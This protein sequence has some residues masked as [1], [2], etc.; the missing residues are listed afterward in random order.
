MAKITSKASLVLGT[1]LKLHIA[2]KS[3]TD[4]SITKAGSV[5]TIASAT[6]N[7]TGSSETGGIV[8]RAIAVGDLIKL[9]HTTSALNEGLTATVTTASGTSLTANIV[10]GTGATESA[11]SLINITTF[12]KTF[13]FLEAGGLSF[14][15]G[16]QGIILASK[17]VD[18][19][20]ASDL[21]KYDRV[22]ASIEPRA[23]SIAAVNGW[24]HHNTSTL[25]A[26]RDT[27]MEIRP[28]ATAAATKIY[29]LFRSTSNA[30]EAT[31]QMTFWPSTDA[32]MTAPN[33]FVMTG[34]A[35]QLALIYDY[36]NGTP[37]DNRGTWYTRLAVQYK[38]II[39]ESH[40]VQY[41]EI[42]P[43][44][45][46]NAIDPKLTVSDV[47]ISAGGIY[48]NIDYNMYAAVAGLTATLSTG[49]AV[50]TV[51]STT[52]LHAGMTLTKTSG[53]GVFGTSAYILSVDN[54]TQ[55]TASINHG[56]AGSI[57]FT[58]GLNGTEMGLVDGLPYAFYGHIDADSQTNEA[59]HA[60]INYLWRQS[61]NVN[62][63]TTPAKRGDKQWPLTTFSGD[64]FTIKSYINSYKAS[65]R[66]YL[67]LVDTSLTTRQW[68]TA[69]TLTV[70]SAALAV[71]GT[72][73]V[74]HE[75]TFGTNVATYLKNDAGVD[76]KDITILS[77]KD[78]TIAYS[79]Y[80]NGGHT[81]GTPIALRLTYNRPGYIE[82]DST[83]FTFD[84]D[85]SVT[86][87]P[88]ADPS[89]TA[90]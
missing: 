44:S 2:D 81:A 64:V 14:V 46:A 11:G 18:L 71:N 74:I 23:K 4:I 12:K 43:I 57:T 29:A 59:V 89:Y 79:T 5:L 48:A 53:T 80:T 65:Q 35:N 84:R 27:A 31:D 76:Q 8:N 22:F 86:I 13:E 58:A 7:F 41:A 56:T 21:D 47:T 3:G 15:D 32:E 26:I 51:A 69:Y 61:T 88:V 62:V 70:N 42:Y 9:S 82:P 85:M 10:S 66:N 1:N 87:Q 60:K 75:D 6:A 19:W 25:N 68:P 49:T 34:Y 67:R 55:F 24:E 50:V 90:A 45:A 83:A 52:G 40:N 63:Q 38:T 77:T 33:N 37:I 72:F 16:V 36:N 73:S 30:N 28:S 39:M 20:D 54:A 78:I 17:L